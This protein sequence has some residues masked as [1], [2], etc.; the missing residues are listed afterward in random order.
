M[1]RTANVSKLSHSLSLT[2]ARTVQAV[3]VRDDE[4]EKSIEAALEIL[5]PETRNRVETE[6]RVEERTDQQLRRDDNDFVEL[7]DEPG[8]V[9]PNQLADNKVDR[10]VIRKPHR[11]EAEVRHLAQHKR[12]FDLAHARQQQQRG[13][14]IH[15]LH[16]QYTFRSKVEHTLCDQSCPPDSS[17]HAVAAA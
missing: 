10:N 14:M 4:R 17:Q 13:D 8:D 12:R 2:H 5:E 11:R 3:K 16:T 15:A 1:Q 7:F 6:R 9:P